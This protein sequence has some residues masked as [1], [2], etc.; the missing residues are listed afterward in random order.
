MLRLSSS[1]A[2]WVTAVVLPSVLFAALS[3]VAADDLRLG[4][5][6]VAVVVV[7]GVLAGT[8]PAVLAAGISAVGFWYTTDPPADGFQLKW[9]AGP[10]SLAT[11]LAVCATVIA[12][13]AERDR[14]AA[15]A[16]EYERRY[17]RLSDAGIVG[18]LFWDP[19]GP[20]LDANDA[21]LNLVGATPATTSKPGG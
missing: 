6:Y 15:Q 19:N 12:A 2:R 5:A 8:W 14:R 1:A 20:L 11:F 16:L 17:R 10:L 21:F 7:V 9:P 3:A 4:T 13:I 18:T